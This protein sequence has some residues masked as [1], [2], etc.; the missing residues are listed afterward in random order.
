MTDTETIQIDIFDDIYFISD[1]KKEL[2]FYVQPS[3]KYKIEGSDK[4]I[5]VLTKGTQ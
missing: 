5:S 3:I 2:K 1:A 4:D